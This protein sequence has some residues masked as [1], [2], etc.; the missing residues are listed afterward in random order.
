MKENEKKYP[1]HLEAEELL[2]AVLEQSLDSILIGNADGICIR[3]SKIFE[4]L[5]GVKPEEILGKHVNEI[6]DLHFYD[7]AVGKELFRDKK[8]FSTVQTYARTGKTVLS[9]AYPVFDGNGN[10]KCFICTNRDMDGLNHLKQELEESRK[11]NRRYKAIMADIQARQLADS[12]MVAQSNSMQKI[13][14]MAIRI[15]EYSVPV[16]IT[17]ESGTGKEVL[18]QFIHSVSNR[19][20]QPFITINCATLPEQLVESELFGYLPGAFTGADQKGKQGL[21]ELAHNGTLF[22][23]EIGE[24]P[25]P[26]Q[27]K[28]L[29]VLE[30]T[31]V[32]RLGSTKSKQIDVRIIAATNRILE[33]EVKKGKF[34][35]DLYFRLSVLPILIPSLKDRQEDILPLIKF[36]TEFFNKKYGANKKM[37][38]S[39]ITILRNH[40]WPGNIRELRNL[41]ERLF[42][43][44]EGELITSTDLPVQFEDLLR[45]ATTKADENSSTLKNSLNIIENEMLVK[46]LQQYGSSRKA[47]ASLG[48]TQ[49]TFLRKLHSYEQK[50]TQ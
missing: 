42:V 3:V 39:L 37:D 23:D 25:L 34:R 49:S 27:A 8:P 11:E 29:R 36:F 7:N 13:V 31:T 17:G 10:I 33:D 19:N 22:L 20:K 50:N 32:R 14:D 24:L 12:R 43:C 41:I 2:D 28:L 1:T 48:L 40:V 35:E 30:D 26:I 18:A 46:A 44:T 9:T 45:R 4:K 15:A 47:A 16:L 21:F 6:V 5:S 38:P